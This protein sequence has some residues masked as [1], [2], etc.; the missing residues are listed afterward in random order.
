MSISIEHGSDGVRA[1]QTDDEKELVHSRYPRARLKVAAR[2]G[3]D[4][5][6]SRLVGQERERGWNENRGT[7]S[8]SKSKSKCKSKSWREVGSERDK[9]RR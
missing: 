5:G 6:G 8:K 2:G 4:S 3:L 7:E 1:C 9:Q